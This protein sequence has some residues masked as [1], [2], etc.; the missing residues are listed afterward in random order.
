MGN[1]LSI[2][3]QSLEHN[4]IKTRELGNSIIGKNWSIMW[5]AL[6]RSAESNVTSGGFHVIVHDGAHSHLSAAVPLKSLRLKCRFCAHKRHQEE[7]GRALAQTVNTRSGN[8]EVNSI[9]VVYP[10]NRPSS[11]HSAARLW[12]GAL[13]GNSNSSHVTRILYYELL[14]PS[15]SS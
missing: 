10:E 14:K 3:G 8:I 2:M 7:T 4:R 6:N 11:V 1:Y 12:W 5:Q 9:E 15:L 13:G